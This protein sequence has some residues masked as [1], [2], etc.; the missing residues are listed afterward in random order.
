MV[1]QR[2]LQE[3]LTDGEARIQDRL[4]VSVDVLWKANAEVSAEDRKWIL[5]GCQGIVETTRRT[6]EQAVRGDEA[7]KNHIDSVCC[8]LASAAA[9]RLDNLVVEATLEAIRRKRETPLYLRGWWQ[10]TLAAVAAIGALHPLIGPLI[11]QIVAALM[12]K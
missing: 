11:R 3:I 5:G 6:A 9:G 10:I 4:E 1:A 2:K 8:A 7:S 12:G